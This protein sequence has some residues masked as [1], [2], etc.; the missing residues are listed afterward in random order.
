MKGDA[1]GRSSRLAGIVPVAVMVAVAA[2]L[3]LVQIG[4]R[5]AAA[6]GGG[7]GGGGGI[8]E[9]YQ[10]DAPTSPPPT[11]EYTIADLDP[12]LV[13]GYQVNRGVTDFPDAEDMSTPEAAYA[14]I[15]RALARGDQG[16]WRR[17]T[18]DPEKL[19]GQPA[20]DAPPRPVAPEVARE[21]LGCRVVEVWIYRD[22]HCLVIAEMPSHPRYQYDLRS[23]RLVDGQWLNLGNSAAANLE[24]ARSHFAKACLSHD[25]R[26]D[27]YEEALTHPE[28]IV[29][30]AKTLFEAIRGADYDYFLNSA[31]PDVW[32]E[33][34]PP[35][36]EADYMVHTDYP[37]WVAWVCTTFRRNPI[38]RV[39]L[40]E[41]FEGE[42]GRPTIPYRLALKDGAILSGD[43]PF[44]YYWLRGR[45]DWTAMEGL[46][47][48]L[49]DPD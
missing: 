2:A 11:P 47:W 19:P 29:R 5:Q 41:V 14:T 34:P 26:A 25:R 16:I 30:M 8:H 9:P 31:K 46:D 13:R 18:G 7:G 37:S 38:V 44:M 45:D 35:L 36:G 40:G 17:I 20:A 22:W 4:A 27:K 10:V 43:L 28:L 3:A 49:R 21:R 15:N 23:L 42:Y 48:H 12:S 6:Q 39:E 33:F 32:K 1:T 24:L